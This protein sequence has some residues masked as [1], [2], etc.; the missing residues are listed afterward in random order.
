MVTSARIFFCTACMVALAAHA[1][2]QVQRG[3][4]HGTVHDQ[5]GAVLPGALVEITSEVGAPREVA[6]GNRGDYRF[7][8]LD[9]GRYTL[10]ATLAGFAPLVR[11]DVI[12]AVGASVDVRIDMRVGG[13]TEELIVNA[14]SPVLDARRLGNVTNFD[15]VMLEQVP[16]AR[17]P[18]ALM[19]H[20]PG[21]SVGRPNVGGSESTNQAQHGARADEIGRAHV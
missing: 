21:V 18:W 16:T 7:Q 4:I 10:R 17:D 2:A 11:P 15:N 5:S 19:Q 20:L 9:P 14:A 8:E 13:V 6:A 3:V 12:V 1:S